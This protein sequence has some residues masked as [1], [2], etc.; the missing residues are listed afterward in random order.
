YPAYL[1]DTWE[2]NGAAWTVLD[3]ES[4]PPGRAFGGAVYDALHMVTL[5]FGGAVFESPSPVDETWTLRWDSARSLES[6][7]GL[8]S[9]GDGLAGCDDPDCF[10]RCDPLC[11]PFLAACDPSRPRCGDGLC[12]EALETCRLCP[13]D[14]G[15]CPAQCGDLHCDASTGESAASC[16]GDCPP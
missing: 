11:A 2:W 16:P 6:C 10:G 4:P 13:V 1:G 8:D 12:Q 5:L 3:A 15:P 7:L 14:C 9:D